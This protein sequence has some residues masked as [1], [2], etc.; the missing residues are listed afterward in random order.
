MI[1][2]QEF[3]SDLHMATVNDR[4]HPI[5]LKNVELKLN[6]KTVFDQTHTCAHIHTHSLVKEMD[7]KRSWDILKT[8]QKSETFSLSETSEG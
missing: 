1:K 7:L 8:E 6:S 4:T 3:D 5:F 2:T